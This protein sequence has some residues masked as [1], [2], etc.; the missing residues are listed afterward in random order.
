MATRRKME[1]NIEV[2][3]EGG[4][5]IGKSGGGEGRVE[6]EREVE[7]EKEGVRRR[8]RWRWRRKECEDHDIYLIHSLRAVAIRGLQVK[9]D[10]VAV[11][12]THPLHVFI[13]EVSGQCLTILR[14]TELRAV[15]LYIH[16]SLDRVSN[17][18]GINK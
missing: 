11:M 6:V 10:S 12:L 5:W 13:V 18:A 17:S 3:K 1:R 4:R 14:L 15:R 7:V 2:E 9:L 8:E 16:V